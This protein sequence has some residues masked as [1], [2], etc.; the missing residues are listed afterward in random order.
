M[1]LPRT[2]IAVAVLLAVLAGLAWWQV[3]PA[4]PLI[5]GTLG[6]TLAG[7]IA[8]LVLGWRRI[9]WP[10]SLIAAIG[11]AAGAAGLATGRVDGVTEVPR[12]L[13][14]VLSIGWPVDG[15]SG[16]SATAGT[17]AFLAAVG[18]VA[19]AMRRASA[20]SVAAPAVAWLVTVVATGR[21]LLPWWQ[22]VAVVVVIGVWLWWRSRVQYLSLP[23]LAG[24]ATVARQHLWSARLAATSAAAVGLGALGLVTPSMATWA[25]PEG[26]TA[27]EPLRPDDNPLA[28]LTRLLTDPPPGAADVDVE[29]DVSGPSPGRL[30]LAVL[31]RY[32]GST[33]QQGEPYEIT[34]S[35][36]R[37]TVDNDPS[38]AGPISTVRVDQ[39]DADTGLLAAPSGGVLVSVEQPDDI[40]YAAQPGLL[41]SDAGARGS[42]VRYRSQPLQATAP[43]DSQSAATSSLPAALYDCPESATIRS[44]AS[45]LA[46][47]SGNPMGTLRS[48]ESF[49]K[50]VKI[51]DPSAPGGQT[52]T[53]V[54]R[55]VSQPYARGNLE[56]FMSSFALLARCAGVP[57]RLVV[58]YPAPSGDTI[59]AYRPIDAIGWAE[60]SLAGVGWVPIDPIPTP[61][62]QDRQA[63]LA[64]Q[65]P[66]PVVNPPDPAVNEPSVVTAVSPPTPKALTPA[67]I[68]TAGGALIL[69]S[70][71]AAIPS[72]TRRRRRRATDPAIAVAGAWAS[73]LELLDA[74]GVS[75]RASQTAREVVTASHGRVTPRLTHL[76]SQLTPLVDR[77]LFAPD[78]VGPAEAST[79]W[80]IEA[81]VRNLERPWRYRLRAFIEA[82]RTRR[83]AWA[84]RRLA[85][86]QPWLGTL[87]ERTIVEDERMPTLDGVELHA[88][89]GHG[90]SATVYRGRH[91]T[92]LPVA[93]K[94]FATAL[95]SGSAEL[96]RFDWERRVLALV[97][98]TPGLPDLIDSGLTTSGR[99]YLVT[100]LFERGTL[101]SRVQ[102]GGPLA[103]GELIALAK[104]LA[105]ALDALHSASILHADIKPENVFVAENGSV[106]LGDLGSAWLA[107][108][109][110]PSAALTPEYAAPEI[111]LGRAPTTASDIY[112]LGATLLFAATGD[113][114]QAG[115]PRSVADAASTAMGDTLV[116]MLETDPRRRIRSARQVAE[117]LGAERRDGPRHSWTSLGDHGSANRPVAT[118][119]QAPS[120]D[121]LDLR[122]RR[123][124]RSR[125]A[126][127]VS[128]LALAAA[129]TAF[130]AVWWLTRGG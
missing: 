92:G 90:A 62:E 36:L 78:T 55:F 58:G 34:G 123:R 68:A 33:W 57:V 124:T 54:E 125:E 79:A 28:V 75:F 70:G 82:R 103:G 3:L 101:F 6:G 23:P 81:A 43:V 111:S 41:A 87:D 98:G 118:A 46:A 120:G 2:D 32:D 1:R 85:Q 13:R 50:L 61:A 27:V 48:I 39:R 73:T 129:A 16:L 66:A 47:S 86:G 4:G 7:S 59:T 74:H 9:A 69:A 60:T 114:P 52:L 115:V 108:D 40:L 8:G 17:S 5:T 64:E 105:A 14:V 29:V 20:W 49:L 19:A 11:L 56:V 25:P 30:R 22:A 35:R 89:I 109:G 94:V 91:R 51:Y 77:S 65:P 93:V 63:Q 21:T 18:G 42:D 88:V 31:D 97:S 116:A 76:T 80:A 112:S 12:L 83:A 10:A 44:A 53:S 45:T 72:L 99:P 117:R 102:A 130:L 128:A 96:Q 24:S 107:A 84:T 122:H 95:R 106:V 121:A 113:T 37:R 38:L 67:L 104:D 100:T 26:W 15:L 71:W 127:V 126:A 110:A 119:D